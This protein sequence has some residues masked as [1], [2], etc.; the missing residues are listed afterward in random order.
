[1]KILSIIT[2]TYNVSSSI[3]PTLESVRKIKTSEMEYLVID[4]GSKDDTI[5]VLSKYKDVIDIVISERDNGI[6]DAM[7]KGLLLASGLFIININAGDALYNVPLEELKNLPSEYCG[8]CG[9]VVDQKGNYDI[10]KFNA[11]IKVENQ[12]PHQGMFYRKVDVVPYDLNFR[13]FAD[14]DLN[15]KLFEQGKRI[16]LI[17]DVISLHSLDGV[18]MNPIYAAERRSILYKHFGWLGLVRL[19]L[20][21]RCDGL[22]RRL[23]FKN[24]LMYG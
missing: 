2:V 24:G 10:P 20:Y 8:L 4:G 6:Y 7:N 11:M 22:F 23:G 19:W 9:C 21:Y 13:I 14:Y 1:M 12:I 15:L 3:I 16:K 17:N 5:D 18:S